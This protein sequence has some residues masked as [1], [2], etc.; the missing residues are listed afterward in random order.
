M[1]LEDVHRITHMPAVRIFN[2]MKLSSTSPIGTCMAVSGLE[3]IVE[4]RGERRVLL[5]CV[6]APLKTRLAVKLTE[7]CLTVG[8]KC[9]TGRQHA[10]AGV[11]TTPI[12]HVPKRQR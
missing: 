12:N 4:K 8:T 9:W 11:F 5:C 7:C 2:P 1:Q 10:L 6:N 3:L